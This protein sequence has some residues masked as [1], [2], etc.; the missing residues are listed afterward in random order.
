MFGLP[1]AKIINNSKSHGLLK[2]QPEIENV[3]YANVINFKNIRLIYSQNNDI[4]YKENKTKGYP[5]VAVGKNIKNGDIVTFDN[6]II[7]D[8]TYL[9]ECIE[10]DESDSSNFYSFLLQVKLTTGDY[11]EYSIGITT[12]TESEDYNNFKT[13]GNI[14]FSDADGDEGEVV[15]QRDN[16]FSNLITGFKWNFDTNGTIVR[17]ASDTALRYT[18]MRF[19]YSAEINKLKGIISGSGQIEKTVDYNESW[20]FLSELISYARS[21]MIQ[22]S[23]TI[24]QVQLEYDIDPGLKIGDIVEIYRPG[25][26]VQGKFAVKEINYTFKNEIKQNWQITLKSTDLITTYIDIFRPTEQEQS[27]ETI[28][29]VVLSEFVEEEIN[30]KHSLELDKTGHTLNFNL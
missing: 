10:N 9:R 19:M 16:F 14:T 28:N 11:K 15:L 3:D 13:K 7:V 30:E 2:I 29:T 17:I 24:N 22:N 8:E 25:F 23:N 5:I 1:P 6:P 4:N 18:T 12:N 21:L 26:Y 27:K 20:T